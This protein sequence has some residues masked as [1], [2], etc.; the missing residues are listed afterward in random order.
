[1]SPKEKKGREVGE[2]TTIEKIGQ[3]PKTK[4]GN[5]PGVS[6]RLACS[7]Y[8]LQDIEATLQ[9]GLDPNEQWTEFDLEDLHPDGGCVIP[10]HEDFSWAIDNVPLLASLVQGHRDTAALM[11]RRG[12]R[13]D[14]LN[15]LE[16]TPWPEAISRSDS[17][18]VRFPV[19]NGA[20]VKRGGL[21][22]RGDRPLHEAMY[23]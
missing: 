10:T 2:T 11:V 23:A 19:E 14:V 22:R 18:D 8:N 16:W 7:K 15:A 9:G 5:A 4:R 20:P 1:M 6:R 13:D 3:Y 21:G 17:D 12:A